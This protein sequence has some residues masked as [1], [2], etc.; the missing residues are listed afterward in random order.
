MGNKKR[1]GLLDEEKWGNL[2]SDGGLAETRLMDQIMMVGPGTLAGGARLRT[3]DVWTLLTLIH[4]MRRD[5]WELEQEFS[6]L[7][8]A[9]EELK[10]SYDK[11][12]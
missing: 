7:E 1:L 6:E 12:M 10:A 3:A 9:Y 4:A 2:L 5:H 8:E 11:I